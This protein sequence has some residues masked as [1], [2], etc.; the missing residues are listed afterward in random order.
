MQYLAKESQVHLE[1]S[2]KHQ[3]QFPQ[4]RKEIRDWPL[5][6]KDVKHMRPDNDPAQE[7]TI[8]SAVLTPNRSLSRKGFLIFMLILGS[9]ALYGRLRPFRAGAA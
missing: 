3:Q 5:F 6:P 9:E 7:P 1:T 8:F 4:V 2:D